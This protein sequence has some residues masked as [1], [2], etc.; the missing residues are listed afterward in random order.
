M[1]TIT[2]TPSKI[3]TVEDVCLVGKNMASVTFSP[4]IL[5]KVKRNYKEVVLLQEKVY[6]LN[7]GVADLAA[8]AI[9]N[10]EQAQKNILLSHASGVGPTL[11]KELIR[12]TIFCR[13]LTFSEGG[14][15]I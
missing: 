13:L 15:G 12:T 4:E 10:R 6:G 1:K 14:S 3:Y 2:I 5:D 8:T 9:T 11:D 7:T